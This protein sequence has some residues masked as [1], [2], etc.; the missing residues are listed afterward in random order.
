MPI[1][2]PFLITPQTVPGGTVTTTTTADAPA[3][4][5]IVVALW[6]WQTLGVVVDAVISD[7][8]ANVYSKII[9]NGTNAANYCTA[10]TPA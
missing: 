7:G 8:T 5:T 6:A 9:E 1:G 3:G 10:L 4:S 2:T